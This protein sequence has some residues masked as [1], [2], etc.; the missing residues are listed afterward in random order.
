MKA[1]KDKT[2]RLL[3]GARAAGLTI[4]GIELDPTGTL[5]V[6]VNTSP[7]PGKGGDADKSDDQNEWDAVR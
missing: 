1:D 5:R 4:R 6:L 7:A 3:K 2:A